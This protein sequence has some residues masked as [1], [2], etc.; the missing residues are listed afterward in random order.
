MSC[1]ATTV[2]PFPSGRQRFLAL[3]EELRAQ[4][5][6]HDLTRVWD[7]MTRQERIIV[8]KAASLAPQRAN[9][10]L[11]RFTREERIALRYAIHRMST[12]AKQLGDRPNAPAHPSRALAELALQALAQHDLDSANHF[13][14]LIAQLSD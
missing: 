9:D 12:F 7:A 8:L 3:R 11:T 4:H 5:S 2:I 14:T 1:L 13:L 10:D 6:D